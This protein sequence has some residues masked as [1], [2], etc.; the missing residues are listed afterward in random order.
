[1]SCAILL[2]FEQED[3]NAEETIIGKKTQTYPSWADVF[4]IMWPNIIANI[5]PRGPQGFRWTS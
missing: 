5:L 4:K 1:M 3:K 2:V